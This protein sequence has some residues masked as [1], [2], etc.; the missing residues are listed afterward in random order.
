MSGSDDP[1]ERLFM[2][3]FSATRPRVSTMFSPNGFGFSFQIGPTGLN[4]GP[5]GGIMDALHRSMVQQGGV[6]KKA[7][8]SFIEGL[9]GPTEISGECMC[10][11]CQDN[12]ELKEDLVEL[13]CSHVYHR[14]CIMPW[15][16]KSNTCP[17]CR[18]EF[19]FEEYRPHEEEEAAAAAA[20]ASATVS[21]EALPEMDDISGAT[22]ELAEALEQ[23]GIHIDGLQRLIQGNGPPMARMPSFFDMTARPSIPLTGT[24]TTNEAQPGPAADSEEEFDR[25]LQ[26]AI[27]R[28]MRYS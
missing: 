22:G 19:E 14:D 25:A 28:S 21:D 12:C 23:L 13:P 17:I 5:S 11:V 7:S 27:Y 18:K 3:M 24:T 6:H 2:S 4:F 8:K 1:I 16:E 26:E 15:F 20:T 9:K 10:G